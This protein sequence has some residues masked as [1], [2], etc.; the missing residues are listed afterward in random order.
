MLSI[1]MS[2]VLIVIVILSTSPSYSVF[3]L[4]VSKS[5]VCVLELRETGIVGETSFF[6][7]PTRRN[8][9]LETSGKNTPVPTGHKGYWTYKSGMF[10]L[11]VQICRCRSLSSNQSSSRPPNPLRLKPL[12]WEEVISSILV[13][14]C[15][16]YICS[17]WKNVKMF[18]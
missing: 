1:L 12:L 15:I 7:N 18:F 8:Y 2:Q 3:F 13:I 10:P 6:S 5:S 17:W 4:W 11:E 9:V 16:S 14:F